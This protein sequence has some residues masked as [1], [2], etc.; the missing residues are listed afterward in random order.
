M[1][2]GIKNILNYQRT[3]ELLVG[4]DSCSNAVAL[5]LNSVQVGDTVETFISTFVLVVSICRNIYLAGQQI[6]RNPLD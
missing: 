4:V 5:L 3:S 2:G 6:K 1:S